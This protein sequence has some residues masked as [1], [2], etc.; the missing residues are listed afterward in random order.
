[1]NRL[2]MA[3][4]AVVGGAATVKASQEKAFGGYINAPEL[5]GYFK[6]KE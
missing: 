4:A 2:W 6:L 5:N 3:P 1:M